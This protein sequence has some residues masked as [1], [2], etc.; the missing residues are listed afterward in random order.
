MAGTQIFFFIF[1]IFSL[2]PIRGKSSVPEFVEVR[3]PGIHVP[4][5]QFCQIPEFLPEFVTNSI[6]CNKLRLQFQ[7]KFFP[8]ILFQKDILP[9][10]QDLK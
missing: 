3:V 1:K 5:I 4:R 9:H 2:P 10:P 6:I 7:G 8:N